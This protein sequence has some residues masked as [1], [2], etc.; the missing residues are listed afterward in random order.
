MTMDTII[1]IYTVRAPSE[2]HKERVAREEYDMG[3]Y[4]LVRLGISPELLRIL[5]EKKDGSFLRRVLSGDLDRSFFVC[6]EPIPFLEGWQFNG[7]LQE[8]W[9]AHMMGYAIP[10]HFIVLGR[11]NCLPWLLE[12]FLKKLKSLRW[13]LPERQFGED[14]QD[15]VDE[16][17]RQY[18]LAVELQ[19]LDT[20]EDYKRLQLRSVFPVTVLDFCSQEKM[21]WADL[22]EGSRWLDMES[23]EAKRERLERQRAKA[24]YFSLKKE[25]KEPQKALYQLDT[26][27]KNG[28]N[29]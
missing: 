18:G 14:A 6:Q 28:Y 17:C 27:P 19:L 8:E 25:W 23:S 9:L 2:F 22:A 7:Y 15:Y 29:T 1:Y 12:P 20:E 26:I 24:V 10:P 5:Q 16:I 13:I 21:F 11:V 3:D 4:Q